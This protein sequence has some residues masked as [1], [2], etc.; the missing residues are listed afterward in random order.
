MS[1]AMNH[2]AKD[3]AKSAATVYVCTNLRMSGNSCANEKSKG[4]LKAL[5][6]RADERALNGGTLVTVRSSVCMGYCAKGP[7]VKIIGGAFMHGVQVED[8]DMVLDA[9]ESVSPT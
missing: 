3:K 9:A 6:K 4:V 8:V 7:N 5:Q 1:Y 2:S